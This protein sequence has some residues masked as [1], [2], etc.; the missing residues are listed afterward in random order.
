MPHGHN[1]TVT[2]TLRPTAPAPLDGHANMVEPFE[3]AKATWHRWIDD[4]VDHSLHLAAT[5]PLLD[6]FRTREP[7]RVARIMVTPGDPTTE[8]LAACMLSKCAAFLAADGARLACVA[9]EIEETPTNLVKLT[10]D[11]TAWLP[12]AAPAEAWW[13]RPDMSINDLGAPA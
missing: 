3:R 8:V 2:V 10:G 4:H 13:T 12:A 1:E 6:W 7:Q 5:D 9:I 11:A